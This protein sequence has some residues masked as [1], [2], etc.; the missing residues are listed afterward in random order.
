MVL[1]SNEREG[2]VLL[3]D[4]LAQLRR[5][6]ARAVDE[7]EDAVVLSG[8][9][10]NPQ[11]PQNVSFDSSSG[12]RR[13]DSSGVVEDWVLE[14]EEEETD[15]ID[16]ASVNTDTTEK[17]EIE[18]E[19]EKYDKEISSNVENAG[20]DGEALDWNAPEY[21][22]TWLSSLPGTLPTRVAKTKYLRR[23]K[24]LQQK[25]K[26]WQLNASTPLR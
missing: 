22:P 6:R 10:G 8:L 25:H 7:K 21:V 17:L 20:L 16:I 3:L 26:K 24:R 15:S 9:V 1:I 5:V 4:I 12:P 11:N 2:T 18:E 13:I 14:E 23:S 19:E